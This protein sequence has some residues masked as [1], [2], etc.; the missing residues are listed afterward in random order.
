MKNYIF[1]SLCCL[2]F[3][4]G[5]ISNPTTQAK[6]ALSK[7]KERIAYNVHGTGTNNLV[8]IHGWSCDSRYWKNQIATLAK[9]HKVITIDLAGH[10]HSSQNRT[11]YTIGA[12]AEDIKAVIEKEQI[13]DLILIGHS[14]G[15]A[16]VAKTAEILPNKIKGLIVVDTMQNIEK[17]LSAE[18]VTS[19]TLPFEQDF[20]NSAKI[21]VKQ[22]FIKST[23]E[24]IV[25]WVQEDMSSAPKHAALSSFKNYMNLYATGKTPNLF[26][27]IDIPVIS[28]NAHLWPTDPEANKKH[29]KDYTLIYIENSGHFPMFENPKEFNK[30]L[31][32]AV[33][34]INNK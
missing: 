18:E 7:D 28:I 11:N 15:G 3:S 20:V 13:D 6:I 27:T 12:F 30:L 23:N 14:M 17:T 4:S 25:K 1:I 5:C 24:D 9:K 32:E 22:M 21:F 19:M 29:I 31:L 26:K 34:K 33:K 2:I 10:G 16:V 8:L